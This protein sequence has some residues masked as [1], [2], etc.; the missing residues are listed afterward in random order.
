MGPIAIPGQYQ[1][2]PIPSG[3]TIIKKKW[4]KSYETIN[5][6][7]GDRI[8]MSWDIALSEAGTGDYSVGVVMQAR[9]RDHQYSGGHSGPL[10]I[11]D[12]KAEN[13]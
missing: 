1:Q 9:K 11:R 3:G 13:H 6:Q 2:T 10:S 8:I 4:L 5:N 7:R 12:L